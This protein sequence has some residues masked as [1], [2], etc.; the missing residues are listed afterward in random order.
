MAGANVRGV[1]FTHVHI[2]RGYRAGIRYW[3]LLSKF[4]RTAAE[5]CLDDVSYSVTEIGGVLG[6]FV[7]QMLVVM[8]TN[9]IGYEDRGVQK[10]DLPIHGILAE[11]PDLRVK[12]RRDAG[13]AVSATR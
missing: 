4:E 8:S 13:T 11:R 7:R 5:R 6:L 10:R 9:N 3:H 2:V 12:R 1:A